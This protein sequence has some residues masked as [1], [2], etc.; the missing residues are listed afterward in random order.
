M[1]VCMH[2]CM[3]VCIF[4][5]VCV[6]MFSCLRVPWAIFVTH[7]RCKLYAPSMQHILIIGVRRSYTLSF[8]TVRAFALSHS[9]ALFRRTSSSSFGCKGRVKPPP[10]CPAPHVS[11]AF[12]GRQH[13]VRGRSHVPRNRQTENPH[14]SVLLVCLLACLLAGGMRVVNP[15]A[16]RPTPQG[17]LQC[18]GMAPSRGGDNA[19]PLFA[20]G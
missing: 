5:G 19:V 3:Y 8:S 13:S 17:A 20:P 9:V 11:G 18:N 16:R 15:L 10:R 4:G 2:A 7:L 1:Y 12:G 6:S 14:G